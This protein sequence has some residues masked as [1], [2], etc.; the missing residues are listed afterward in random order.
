VNADGLKGLFVNGMQYTVRLSDCTDGASNT[1]A[2]G[3]RYRR[4]FD[5]DLALQLAPEYTG[6]Y[7]IGVAPDT[8]PGQCIAPLLPSPAVFAINGRSINAFAS[9]HPGGAHFL[10]ADGS[11]R[12]INEY[13]DQYVVSRMGTINDGEAVQVP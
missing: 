3:E 12:F 6:A 10:I 9:Q 7:W 2:V 1:L 8:R 4:E 5:A 13:S 11:V